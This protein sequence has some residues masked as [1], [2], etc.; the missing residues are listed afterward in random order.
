MKDL[1]F[2]E[3]L[4]WFIILGELLE[5]HGKITSSAVRKNNY[6]SGLFMEESLKKPK[7]YRHTVYTDC[8]HTAYNH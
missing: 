7:E 1:D 2:T 3:V 8:I 5:S 6:I 4:M